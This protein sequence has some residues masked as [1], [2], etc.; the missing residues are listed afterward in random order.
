MRRTAEEEHVREKKSWLHGAVG[1]EIYTRSFQDTDGDGFG[2]LPGVTEHLDYLE[3]LGIDLVWL[4]P[5]FPSPDHDHGYDVSD[6]KSV[7]PA[8]GTIAD[9]E[10]LL[11]KAHSL[12][13]KVLLD[14]V[15]NHTSSEH[16]W[17]KKALADPDSPERAMYL[18][19]D[20]APDGGPP[21]NW[22]SHFG[23]PAWT[24]DEASGQYY[25]HLF[26]PE[27]PDLDWRNPDVLEAFD[28]IY[29]FWFEKG[30]DGFRI[31]VAHGLLKDPRFPDNR[32][33]H[34]VGPDAG[35]LERFFA[36][37]HEYDMDQDDNVAIFG[38]W[39]AIADEYNATLLAE[40]GVELKRL[41]RYVGP[42]ALDLAFYLRPG[43]HDWEPEWLVKNQLD[44]AEMEPSGIS[45]T[46]SNHDNARVV[47]R[48]SDDP[49]I[50]AQRAL[51]VT[52]LH[53]GLGGVPFIYYGE[54]LALTSK[55]I[56]PGA[57][58]DP[59]ATRNKTDGGEGR[60]VARTPMPWDTTHANGFTTGTPWI[61]AN[62][63]APHETVEVQRADPAAPLHRYR[64]LVRLRRDHPDLYAA[65][66]ERLKSPSVETAVIQRGTTLVIANLGTDE[67]RVDSAGDD[68]S[69]L[70]A[71][72]DVPVDIGEGSIVVAG[73][74]SAIFERRAG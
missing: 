51:A 32:K 37:D 66:F 34:D 71:S 3:W 19:R 10:A 72:R 23:G 22:L 12:G 45:W 40:S 58:E 50:G 48:Y 70:F 30:V 31:D 7:R 26:L 5:I 24:L 57:R 44:L 65:P 6:Y 43:W 17:F 52:T 73:E 33:L 74:C 1:Y 16:D 60:D 59:V 64:A 25:C 18:F 42:A 67:V 20:P 8:H 4:T 38:R 28:D 29:R 39:Q 14:I 13:M 54:E 68:W 15:P 27:Q 69:L 56:D 9:V 62:P 2:D 63:R 21:N 47:S 11:D 36:Y 55:R 41:V 61:A 46:I 49:Q 53:M 35:P